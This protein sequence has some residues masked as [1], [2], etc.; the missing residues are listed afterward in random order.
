VDPF[1]RSPELYKKQHFLDIF[2]TREDISKP[3]LAESEHDWPKVVVTEN[4]GNRVEMAR[5]KYV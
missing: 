1:F 3:M 5:V 2:N 4:Q